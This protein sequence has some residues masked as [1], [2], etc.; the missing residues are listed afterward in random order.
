MATAHLIVSALLRRDGRL[1]LV[2]QLGPDDPGPHWMLPGGSVEPGESVLEALGREVR[3]ETGMELAGEPRVAILVHL[4]RPDDGYVAL[5]FACEATGTLAPND[6]DGYILEAAWVEERD[7]LA[8]LEQVPWYDTT[9]LRRHL[10]NDAG[11][12]AA[13]VVDRR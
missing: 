6:P 1:L 2:R 5:T 8:R 10:S 7:A 12:G 13:S 4:L 3:E 9:A 11:P